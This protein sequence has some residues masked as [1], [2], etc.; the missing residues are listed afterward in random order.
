MSKLRRRKK[1]KIAEIRNPFEKV[2]SEQFNGDANLLAYLFAK[3]EKEIYNKLIGRENYVVCGG[4]GAGKT[5]LLRYLAL[6]TQF[7]AV[8]K[9]GILKADFIGLYA[10]IGRGAFKPFLRAG[11]EFKDGGEILFGHYFNLILL[12]KL[13]YLLQFCDA[14]SIFSISPL[15]AKEINSSVIQKFIFLKDKQALTTS[16]NTNN[17]ILSLSQLIETFRREIETFL[18]TRDLD[19][20]LN[21]REYL[22]VEPTDVKR[23][24]DEIINDIK[25]EI[26]EIS[27]KRVYLLIDECEQFSIGQQKVINTIIRQRPTTMVFKLASRPPGLISILTVDENIGVSDRELKTLNLDLAYDPMTKEFKELCVEVAR[28]RL[29]KYGYLTKDIKLI[30]GRFDVEN[31]IDKK[32]IVDHIRKR[33]PSKDR[34]KK[35]FIEVYKDFKVAATFQILRE[36]KIDKTYAGF[37]TF[38]S[39]SSG[40]MLHFLELCGKTI[41]LAINQ[42]LLTKN[43]DGKI[44]FKECPLHVALQSKAVHGV[45]EDF[46]QTISQR[47]ES[48]RD[49]IIDFEFGDKIKYIIRILGGIFRE[50]LMS[51]NEPEAARLEIPEGIG[52]LDK[53]ISNPIQQLFKSAIG[54]SVFQQGKSYKPKRVGGI[55]PPTYILNRILTPNLNISTRPRWRTIVSAMSLNKIL[56]DQGKSIRDEIFKKRKIK[57]ESV[58]N[59]MD[60]NQMALNFSK[61]SDNTPLLLYFGNKLKKETIISDKIILVLLHFLTDLV[62]FIENLI[63]LGVEETKIFLIFKNYNYPKKSE[64]IEYFKDKKIN[65]FPVEE[66]TTVLE[67][68]SKLDN[69]ILIIEDGGIITPEIDNNFREISNRIIGTV[70]QTTRGI[71]NDQKI[72]DLLFPIVSIPGSELKNKFEPP[73]VAKAVIKNIEKLL[74]NKDFSGRT[75]LIIGYGPIGSQVAVNVRDRLKM[76]VSVFDIDPNKCLEAKQAG[77]QIVDRNIMVN[78]M[79]LIVG[80]TGETVIGRDDLL[81]MDHNVFLVSASSEQWEFSI[82]ELE[83]LKKDSNP[84]KEDEIIV[85]TKYTIA[86]QEKVINLIADGYPINFWKS[87]SMPN[88]VSDLIMCLIFL[89]AV[90]LCASNLNKE[91]NINFVNEIAEKYEL[92]KT[93]LSF[94]K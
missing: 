13:L 84:I 42:N 64:L 86:G 9:Q 91:I 3:P 77:F 6:E 19:Q 8:G 51:F 41:E 35:N 93:Y 88:Q 14:K 66:L 90:E 43:K 53:E 63:K 16:V 29:E 75:A 83:Y 87:E 17:S 85:G 20:N 10:K 21:Y 73:H 48:L 81:N 12:E 62:P 69:R 60:K 61:Y 71:R 40:I 1:I 67:R 28:K 52:S 59:D 89:C 4:W 38:V 74:P 92:S 39:L 27:N 54:I 80:A 57:I 47:A 70:E 68:I 44:Q 56:Y 23:F 65:V 11:G 82:N 45:S 37:D 5:T 2:T 94:H 24:L 31:E 7:E 30:L 55:I 78:N 36:K 18:N 34:L 22:S 76:N 26:K 49:T 72:E 79:F 15:I 25:K 32:I 33:Y 46:F 58:K 50:K